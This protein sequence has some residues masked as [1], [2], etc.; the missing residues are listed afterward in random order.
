MDDILLTKYLLKETNEAEAAAVRKWIGAHPDHEKRF[1][2][3]QIVW[4]ASQTLAGNSDVDEHDAW[5]RFVQR[6]EEIN[7]S[8]QGQPKSIIRQLS[9][10]RIAATIMLIS[11]VGLTGYYVLTSSDGQLFSSNY[12]TTDGVRTD[13]LADGSI[14]TLNRH[15]SM[16]FSQRPFQRKRQVELREGEAFFRVAPNRKKPF[17]IQ[18]GG[19]TVTVLGTSFH[20]KRKGEATAVTVESGK[21]KVEGLNRTIELGPKQKVT[22][23]T[24]TQ[25]FDE[26]VAADQLHNY[27]VSNRFVLDNTPLWRIAEILEEAYDV[28]IVIARDEIRDLP[29]TTTFHHNTLEGVLDVIAKTL[30][31]TAE[32]KGNNIVFN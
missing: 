7:R 4:D 18:S 27:Y 3:L 19:V 11:A 5:Q 30:E 1:A 22:I 20:V 24:Q 25:Q 28:D 26:G 6:R 12:E 23:N 8:P 13:T 17:V 14:I 31:V 29:M 10:L 21:V 2:Q 32:K 9:W 16:R 15:A